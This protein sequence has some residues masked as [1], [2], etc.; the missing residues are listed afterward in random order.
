ME[1]TMEKRIVLMLLVVGTSGLWA[2]DERL[3]EDP[4]A[5]T[6]R[7]MKIQKLYDKLEYENTPYPKGASTYTTSQLER[8]KPDKTHDYVWFLPRNY[9]YAP[10]KYR[11]QVWGKIP[12]TPG[13]QYARQLPAKDVEEIIKQRKNYEQSLWDRKYS[14]DRGYLGRFRDWIDSKRY[15]TVR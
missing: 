7:E 3:T 8:M 11:K 12:G 15:G 6:K 1:G 9:Y 14:L 13:L 2:F 4:W 10:Y 5:P